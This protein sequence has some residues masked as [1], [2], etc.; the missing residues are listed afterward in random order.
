MVSNDHIVTDRD[1]VERYASR[2]KDIHQRVYRNPEFRFGSP[3]YGRVRNLADTFAMA[4]NT[5]FGESAQRALMLKYARHQDMQNF[6][7]DPTLSEEDFKELYGNDLEYTGQTPTEAA[8]QAQWKIDEEE[9]ME[10]LQNTGG[11]SAV[12]LFGAGLVGS[13]AHPID[14]GTMIFMP[15]VGIS[16]KVGQVGKHLYRQRRLLRDL[17]RA[18]YG[19]MQAGAFDAA[20]QTPAIYNL[21]QYTQGDYHYDDM[22]MDFAM[23]PVGGG[24]LGGAFHGLGRMFDPSSSQMAVS[25]AIHRTVLTPDKG[26][27]VDPVLKA[28]QDDPQAIAFERIL[29]ETERYEQGELDLDLPATQNLGPMPDG[30]SD[31]LNVIREEIGFVSTVPESGR[32]GEYDDFDWQAMPQMSRRIFRR[33]GLPIDE[34]H[35]QL[36]DMGYMESDSTVSE[37]WE[38]IYKA[39][40]NRDDMKTQF[41]D[42]EAQY[43]F[44]GALRDNAGRSATQKTKRKVKVSELKV[45]QRFKIKGVEV[46]VKSVEGGK[47]EI[48]GS[49]WIDGGSNTR[50]FSRT[51]DSDEVI[52][53]DRGRII[54]PEPDTPLGKLGEGEIL[55]HNTAQDELIW[56]SQEARMAEGEGLAPTGGKIPV[57][58]QQISARVRRGPVTFDAVKRF[59]ARQRESHDIPEVFDIMENIKRKVSLLN[60]LQAKEK[61]TKDESE[62]L[63]SLENQ[64][65]LD[66][67]T[68]WLRGELSTVDKFVRL[69]KDGQRLTSK[70]ATQLREKLRIDARRAHKAQNVRY[71]RKNPGRNLVWSRVK[72]YF[73]EQSRNQKEL[74]TFFANLGLR[75]EF[76][77]NLTADGR[78]KSSDPTTIYLKEGLTRDNMWF[79]AWHEFTHSVRRMKPQTYSRIVDAILKIDEAS[80]SKDSLVSRALRDLENRYDDFGGLPEARM[81]EELTANIVAFASKEKAFWETLATKHPSVFKE[82]LD[83]IR[84]FYKMLRKGAGRGD[85]PG[86]W[87]DAVIEIADAIGGMKNE[88]IGR[89]AAHYFISVEEPK[90][91]RFL[92]GVNRRGGGKYVGHERARRL[93]KKWQDMD[94]ELIEDNQADIGFRTESTPDDGDWE[95][96]DN[97][98]WDFSESNRPKNFRSWWY[99]INHTGGRYKKPKINSKGID[100]YWEDPTPKW[101]QREME[102]LDTAIENTERSLKLLERLAHGGGKHANRANYLLLERNR[103][104]HLA[105]LMDKRNV[106]RRGGNANRRPF[107]YKWVEVD[108]KRVKQ[109]VTPKYENVKLESGRT[110]NRIAEEQPDIDGVDFYRYKGGERKFSSDENWKPQAETEHST[111]MSDVLDGFGQT[112]DELDVY[113]KDVA[114]EVLWIQQRLEYADENGIDL[115]YQYT[116]RLHELQ[117]ILDV[118]E[119]EAIDGAIYRAQ[120]KADPKPKDADG[121]F[122]DPLAK[123]KEMIVEHL[124][125]KGQELERMV[126]DEIR[127]L[128][129]E[130]HMRKR[131]NQFREVLKSEYKGEKTRQWIDLSSD[132]EIIEF[133]FNRKGIDLESDGRF[134]TAERVAGDQGIAHTSFNEELGRGMIEDEIDIRALL[135]EAESPEGDLDLKSLDPRKLAE[136]IRAGRIKGRLEEGAKPFLDKVKEV[137]ERFWEK[138]GNN[139]LDPKAETATKEEVIRAGEEA[140]DGHNVNIAQSRAMEEMGS[141]LTPEELA[142][143][144]SNARGE[145]ADGGKSKELETPKLNTNSPTY[146][147]MRK[148]IGIRMTTEK[149]WNL[150]RVHRLVLHA[151]RFWENAEL[152]GRNIK[153]EIMEDMIMTSFADELN[154]PGINNKVWDNIGDP[155]IQI[156]RKYLFARYNP[157]EF[158]NGFHLENPFSDF[159]VFSLLAR[160]QLPNITDEELFDIFRTVNKLQEMADNEG[161]DVSK[162]ITEEVDRTVF[163]SQQKTVLQ[164]KRELAHSNSIRGDGKQ[165]AYEWVATKLDGITRFTNLKRAVTSLTE[166][167][168]A[169]RHKDFIPFY[170]TLVEHGLWDEFRNNRLTKDLVRAFRGEKV[171]HEGIEEVAQ[172]LR[173]IARRQMGET[174]SL[175]GDL[176]WLDS[177]IGFSQTHNANKIRSLGFDGWKARVEQMIDWQATEFGFGRMQIVEGRAVPF[178]RDSY[179]RS[180]YDDIIS[181]RRRDRVYDT[182]TAGGDLARQSSAHRT[183]H[184][185]EDMG[186][187]YDMEFGSGNTAHAMIAQ[188]MRRSEN[189]ALMREFGPDF[190]KSWDAIENDMRMEG[191]AQRKIQRA[192]KVFAFITGEMDN[193]A[194]ADL[195]MW[196]Q[197]AR[198]YSNLVFLWKAGISAMVDIASITSTLK[199]Q[200]VDIGVTDR[201]FWSAWHQ[202]FQRQRLG[203][204]DQATMFLRSTGAGIDALINATSRRFTGEHPTQGVLSHWNDMEFNLNG[205]NL[206][207]TIGQEVTMDFLSRGLADGAIDP[208]V[209]ARFN[210]GEADIKFLRDNARKIDG[211]SG[212]RISPSLIEGSHPE[213]AM[214]LRQYLDH[215]MRE[216]VIEPD[217]GTLTF[218]RLGFKA[219]TYHGEMART[220]LQ[221]LSFP[222][223]LTRKTYSRFLHGYGHENLAQLLMDPKSRSWMHSTSFIASSLAISFI[224]MNIKDLL[225]LREPSAFNALDADNLQRVVQGSGVAGIMEFS[226][227]PL[228][229]NLYDIAK[230]TLEGDLWNKPAKVINKVFETTPGATMPI[231]SEASRGLFALVLGDALIGAESYLDSRLEFIKRTTGQDS[232]FGPSKVT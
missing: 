146:E 210:I 82:F 143:V 89:E 217:A 37:L 153:P 24:V 8:L 116:D 22:L 185:K 39:G 135:E 172:V 66:S 90:L 83:M 7:V 158:P 137:K 170:K 63:K 138:E 206:I 141:V 197:M 209:L 76:D 218:T 52:Y 222:M 225:A 166:M 228:P 144:E 221:Y 2:L 26:Y 118:H 16:A 45:G 17:G 25:A 204:N 60:E 128:A 203:Q 46:E 181:G 189:I 187:D 35:K 117:S 70:Q 101:L 121:K 3:D 192:R 149:V 229:S 74:E 133:W 200:G 56:A 168:N 85:N 134:N 15:N 20:W 51:L 177:F 29:P 59:E 224:T 111:Q 219:G 19:G 61:L 150:F 193:P 50:Y 100:P 33:Q 171:G 43:N 13:M 145:R 174:N 68:S 18:I 180:V 126:P 140:D 40:A 227:A 73:N 157:Q 88:T 12:P 208:S 195:A 9:R 11:R 154:D 38:L 190:K 81:R 179:L 215:A 110:I 109:A 49:T 112:A 30:E 114:E 136:D 95:Q 198:M 178:N 213:L 183:I 196:G 214:K 106:L 62:L 156:F 69:E 36:V 148:L 57:E 55:K 220:G 207:T 1:P 94:D 173:G 226:L 41:R 4:Y 21:Q 91:A 182:E 72:G 175:G 199:Y 53:V 75:I 119:V 194:D 212:N 93:L 120:R 6:Q 155:A 86:E 28:I 34:V 115:E 231:Y 77:R 67:P 44:D 139:K 97:T 127:D 71:T 78:V 84:D 129:V 161:V 124:G 159:K 202:S 223:A 130:A 42:H 27:D 64:L 108:G 167:K 105:Y 191:V 10:R 186:V 125:V 102:R 164:H 131:A 163:K 232:L 160:H 169:Q 58:G 87:D 216:A 32:G 188:M 96:I 132:A 54:T 147:L 142:E 23:G 104:G 99:R 211:L 151:M 48:E 165:S 152:E 14:L 5:S 113:L 92:E 162:L 176:R 107:F 205:L 230:Y 80:G 122:I 184:F 47:V 65:D 31:L 201:A 98:G 123:E 79:V 103:L